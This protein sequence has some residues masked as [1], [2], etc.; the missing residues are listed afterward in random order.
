MP[1]PEVGILRAGGPAPRSR[2]TSPLA[3]AS[4]LAAACLTIAAASL[5]LAGVPAQAAGGV[6][7]IEAA[8]NV[9]VGEADGSVTLPVT[10]SAASTSTVTVN[11]AT[12]NGTGSAYT[13]CGGTQVYTAKSGT[14]TFMPGQTTQNVTINLLNCG[15]SLPS[16]FYTFFVNLTGPSGAS[17]GDSTTQVDITGDAAASSTPGLFVKNAVVDASVGTVEVPV[18]LGGPSGAALNQPVTVDYSTANGSATSGTDYS[19]ENGVLTFPAG[20]TAQNI[21]IPI[22][23]R[24]AATRSFSVTLSSASSNATIASGAGTVT[25][26]GNTGTALTN[27]G[28]S[29]PPNVVVS[30]VDG[31]VDL[32]ITLS[33]PGINAVSVTYNTAN[34]TGSSY[35]NC[36]GV[37]VYE[38]TG[39]QTL[40]FL[41]GVTTQVVRVPLL[42]CASSL[43]SGFYTFSLNLVSASGGTVVDGTTQVDITGTAPASSTPGLFVKNAAVDASVGT[44]EVPVL[45]GGPSGAA[46]NQPVTVG[47]STA[48]GSATAGT[49]YSAENGTLTYPAGVTAENISIPITDRSAATRSFSVTLSSASSNATI[50]NGT[51]TVTIEGNTGTALTNPGISAPPNVVV[52][53]AD[54]YVDLPI[55]LSAPGI[56]AVSVT[57][58]TGNG[59]GVGYVNCG[60]SQIYENESGSVTFPA[61]VT[62]EVVRVPLLNCGISLST[63]F[64]TFFLNLSAVSGATLLDGTTQVDVTGTASAALT[65]GLFVKNAV[66]DASVGTVEVPVLLGGPAGSALASPATVDYSTANGSAKAGT[67]YSTENGTLTFPAGVTAENISVPITDRS[68]ATRSFSVTLSS[69]SSNATIASST[70]T[71]TIEGNKGTAQ[72]SPDIS[73]PPNVVVSAADGYVDLPIM[74]SSPGINPVSVTYG[75]G[76]GTGV[77]YVNCGNS[78]IYENVNGSLTF[79][80]GVTTEVV[81]VPLLNCGTSLSTGF[82]TFFLNLSGV[83]G[84]TLVDGSTQVDITGDAPGGATSGLFVKNAVVDASVGTVEVPVLLGGPS[85]SA[86]GLPVTVTYATA[87]GSAKSGTDYTATNGTLTFPAGVTAENISVP[88]TDRSAATRSF[89]V[90][91]SSASSNAKIASG[92][93]TV[94]IEGN[95]GTAQTSPDISAPPNVVVS[96]AD[97]YV[98][99]PIT[100]S[101]PGINAVS[102]T[103]NTSNGTGVSYASCGGSQIYEGSNNQTV[104]F[105]A[106]VTTQVVRVPLLNCGTS[107]STGFYTFFFNLVGSSGGT[108]V[109]GNTQVD[110]TGNAPGGSTSGLSIKKAVVDASVGTVEVPV[111]LGGPSGSAQGLPVT[112]KYTT[113]DGTAKSG[114]DYTATKGT[115]TF[116]AGVTAENISIP[117]TD[118]SAATRSF[119]VTL[120]SASSNATI[121]AGTGTVTIEANNG[122]AQTNPNISASPNVAVSAADGYVDLPVTLSAPGVNAV[123][124][125]YTTANG[126]GVGYAN[127]GGNQIYEPVSGSLTFPVG[128]TTQVVR[129]PLL[130]CPQTQNLTF[131]LNLSGASHGTITDSTTT[132]T[133]GDFPT[134][135]T[136]TPSAG[137]VGT[138]V[139]ITGSNLQGATSVKFNGKAATIKKDSATK[140]K[141]VVPA[142]ATSGPITITTPVGSVTSSGDFTV[143]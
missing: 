89:S 3:R 129:V 105:P 130:N 111:L 11:Y 141:V 49:D 65:P 2:R 100:L 110:V 73:A 101:S 16:G 24:T 71:V 88:V 33:A 115:L 113:V 8:P 68:A 38:G 84:A 79:P 137:P 124:L 90:T 17:L 98:D 81:R 35:V 66:V 56:N 41:P 109:A 102:V 104:I 132:V 135:T 120:S 12:A 125:N 72:T 37:Q 80:A 74:L 44:V 29:A 43:G 75:T 122:S 112:V 93:G 121:V 14:V 53:E 28:I 78:Q 94:T 91:L 15:V 69:A 58:S 4:E 20:E 54:G 99:L 116:P 32:P 142:G 114:T 139:K 23:D 36:G 62:T 39:N 52:S 5:G 134:I 19:A 95:K 86:Q 45:L 18:L 60:N 77:G 87:N 119:S 42:D 117:I 127:C 7:T 83:S 123:T 82:Y 140:L 106:G 96:A 67:D 30:E 107:L 47:Y 97:G 26:E 6:P 76:N 1:G 103:Y 10:L 55:T 51:G 143:N 57:Y 59:T 31:Y 25:I 92:T 46:L 27:P 133:V 22:T 21:S 48:N 128:I 70:G 63:G 118:R 61:G 138:K 50:A 9:V 108:V 85:G 136:F 13:A 34:G 64:Y 40:T 126:S 131:T